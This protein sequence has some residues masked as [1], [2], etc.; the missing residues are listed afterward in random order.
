[1]MIK[2]FIQKSKIYLLVIIM[3]VTVGLIFF[4]KDNQNHNP[5]EILTIPKK[6]LIEKVKIQEKEQIFELSGYLEPKEIVKISSQTD[7]R[8]KDIL[9]KQGQKVK[10]GQILIILD[11]QE[12]KLEL[13]KAQQL[14]KQRLNELNSNEKL[15]KEKIISKSRYDETM[16]AYRDSLSNLEKAKKY[17]D[18]TKIISPIEGYVDKINLKIGDYVRDDSSVIITRIFS[19]QDFIISTFIPQNIVSLIKSNQNAEFI[20]DTHDNQKIKKS[21]NVGFVSNLADQLTKTY[22][23]EIDMDYNPQNEDLIKLIGSPVSLRIFGP[24]LDAVKLSDSVIFLDDEGEL[25]IK[26]L[27]KN[28]NVQILNV[29]IID[30]LSSENKTWLAFKQLDK[31]LLD[32]EQNLKIIVRGGG[33]LQKNEK[34]NNPEIS[35]EQSE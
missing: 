30:N 4:K 13:D 21:G 17:L 34:V 32:S 25:V 11:E 31:N 12:K 24:K 33:F 16:T 26:V 15:Y 2:N 28:N 1:M 20:I 19:D 29:K 7:G 35:N 6:I 27:D 14:V 10:P 22:Y 23:C 8:I 5:E 9:V 3:F 18:F